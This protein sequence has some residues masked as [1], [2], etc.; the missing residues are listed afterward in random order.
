[1]SPAAA[2]ATPPRHSAGR[3]CRHLGQCAQR[4]YRRGADLRQEEQQPQC[5]HR[6]DEPLVKILRTQRN[7]LA[8]SVRIA[9]LLA[10]TRITSIRFGVR[11]L[12]SSRPCSALVAL[13][14]I[15]RPT[16]PPRIPRQCPSLLVPGEYLEQWERVATGC[17]SAFQRIVGRAPV[18]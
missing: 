15:Q 4:V 14:L 16:V 3:E 12:L 10:F 5:I 1:M 8:L 7:K 6:V 18:E 17:G 13:V 2:A 9:L 11:N